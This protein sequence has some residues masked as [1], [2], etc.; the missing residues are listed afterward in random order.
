MGEFMQGMFRTIRKTNGSIW[1]IT[2]N[3]DDILKSRHCKAILANAGTKVILQHDDQA[4]ANDVAD[5]LGFTDHERDLLFSLRDG[6]YF[7]DILIKAGAQARVYALESPQH[8]AAVLTS[9]PKERNEFVRLLT[10]YG[11]QA[12]AL[13]EF[14]NRKM[15]A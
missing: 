4:L 10:K 14:V 5:V 9:K 11:S 1:M 7:R 8:Q 2:Q 3:I 12:L 13:E 6:G 15:S